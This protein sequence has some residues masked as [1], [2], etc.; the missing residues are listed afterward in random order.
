MDTF[1]CDFYNGVVKLYAET[2]LHMHTKLNLSRGVGQKIG[3]YSKHY[4]TIWL[5]DSIIKRAGKLHVK[6]HS[7]L[8]ELVLRGVKKKTA[9]EKYAAE[10]S[11]LY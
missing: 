5:C 4:W 7:A 9:D 11:C 10:G 1:L 3:F 2:L 6:R 8:T